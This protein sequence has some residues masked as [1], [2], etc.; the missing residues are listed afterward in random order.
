MNI[1]EKKGFGQFADKSVTFDS[2]EQINVKRVVSKSQVVQRIQNELQRYG[3][4][5]TSSDSID[6]AKILKP[7]INL[8]AMEDYGEFEAFYEP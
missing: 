7:K 1:Q 6:R 3:T 2:P 4:V 5:K 8:N